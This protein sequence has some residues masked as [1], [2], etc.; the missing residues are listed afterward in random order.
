MLMCGKL[1]V[2]AARDRRSRNRV[3]GI[4]EVNALI[5]SEAGLDERYLDEVTRL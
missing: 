1:V 3:I 4:T 5:P 2:A